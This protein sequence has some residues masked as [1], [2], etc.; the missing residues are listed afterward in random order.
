MPARTATSNALASALSR[1]QAASD[2]TQIQ[3]TANAAIAAANNLASAIT[4][5]GDNIAKD[6]LAAATSQFLATQAVFN[7]VSPPTQAAMLPYV[8][9]VQDPAADIAYWADV[10]A[11]NAQDIATQA[12]S[13]YAT[14]AAV[15]SGIAG[16]G[17]SQ[18]LL[19]A[20]AD[21][22]ITWG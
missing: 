18:A 11:R 9:A 20:Y 15:L 7:T 1:A 2:F 6:S 8:R 13:T 14:A 17:G 5:N 12:G 16:S 10:I 21:A 19:Q 3:T 4:N 22:P